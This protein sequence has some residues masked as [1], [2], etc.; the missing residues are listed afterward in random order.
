MRASAK[1]SLPHLAS[2]HERVKQALKTN[3]PEPTYSKI[4]Y[5]ARRPIEFFV[6]HRR[7]SSEQPEMVTDILSMQSN[8][9]NYLWRNWTMSLV[10]NCTYWAQRSRS[11]V[12][13]MDNIHSLDAWLT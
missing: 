1:W 6:S 7:P 8:H 4:L 11:P 9:C 10:H 3:Q 2:V 5:T 13:H 12:L